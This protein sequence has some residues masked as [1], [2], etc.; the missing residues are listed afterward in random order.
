MSDIHVDEKI[1]T[2]RGADKEAGSL[3]TA[4]PTDL[5]AGSLRALQQR[6]GLDTEAVG[7]ARAT[8]SDGIPSI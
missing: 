1:H 4:P 7:R 5:L 2:P 6:A 3:H 8:V